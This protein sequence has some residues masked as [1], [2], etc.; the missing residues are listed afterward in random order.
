MSTPV[1]F[2]TNGAA[3]SHIAVE[4]ELARD[5]PQGISSS[6]TAKALVFVPRSQR[7]ERPLPCEFWTNEAGGPAAQDPNSFGIGGSESHRGRSIDFGGSDARDADEARNRSRRLFGLPGPLAPSSQR[8]GRR[9]PRRNRLHA[10]RR[11]RREPSWFR[12]VRRSPK[13]R[14]PRAQPEDRRGGA[15][16]RP[17]GCHVQGV[18]NPEDR[19]GRRVR[20]LTHCHC[21]AVSPSCL[22]VVPVPE[23]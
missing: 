8:I 15:D 12:Q 11:R 16:H 4:I 7:R 23:L 18:R 1:E 10:R 21:A 17:Q 20:L 3:S 2:A 6:Q 9:R 14:A 5:E 13:A 22:Y 19:V